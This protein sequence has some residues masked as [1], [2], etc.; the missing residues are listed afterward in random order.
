M[1]A[2]HLMVLHSAE[3]SNRTIQR[4]PGSVPIRL[5]HLEVCA[6]QRQNQLHQFW[7][8]KDFLRS[9][10]ETPQVFDELRLGPVVSA[11]VSRPH[12]RRATAGSEQM[13]RLKSSL[14][15]KQARQL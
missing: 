13:H 7:M 2:A 8:V 15:V 3:S 4:L 1:F 9:S 6:K 12:L 14:R 5:N 10:V 11:M